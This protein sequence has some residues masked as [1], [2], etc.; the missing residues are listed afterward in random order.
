MWHRRLGKS[1]L[2]LR[3]VSG[4]SNYAVEGAPVSLWCVLLLLCTIGS[5]FLSTWTMD[6]AV[7]TVAAM[8]KIGI[9]LLISSMSNNS[10]K[11]HSFPPSLNWLCQKISIT[12]ILMYYCLCKWNK[13][14][15]FIQIVGIL[16]K[17][18]TV[19]APYAFSKILIIKTLVLSNF[20]TDDYS[21][22]G[23][24]NEWLNK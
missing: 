1:W 19:R 22:L 2:N 17:V 11:F 16:E 10:N 24:M 14:T 9:I 12:G 21:I 3:D 4:H 18:L 5:A 6:T 20:L 8:K 15:H 23:W 7:C 13:S